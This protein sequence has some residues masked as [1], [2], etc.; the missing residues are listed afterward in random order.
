MCLRLAAFLS[1]ISLLSSMCIWVVSRPG[2][3]FRRALELPSVEAASLD[4]VEFYG[5][6]LDHDAYV[7]CIDRSCS[8]GWAGEIDI[9]KA[10][11]ID[12]LFQLGSG[13]EFSLVAF[14]SSYSEWSSSLVP[15]DASA[16]DDALSWV[17]FITAT[18]ST[19]LVA[20]V[21]A[22]IDIA[23]ESANSAVLLVCDGLPSCGPEGDLDVDIA[24]IAAANPLSVPIHTFSVSG[25]PAANLYLEGIAD[26]FGGVYVDTATAVIGSFRRGDANWDGAVDI[27][28]AVFLLAAAFISG[29]PAPPCL[30]AADCNDDGSYDPILDSAVLLQS[31]FVP[32]SLPVAPPFSS[33]GGDPT[34]DTLICVGQCP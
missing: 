15:A 1:I 18:G 26:A 13:D 20:P 12:A 8:M 19:C 30:D 5:A 14:D 9:V 23:D 6:C 10:A 4:G 2:S 16:V 25:D 34:P 22:A 27:A 31:I 33:C 21:S 24:A 29:S 3:N 28:D 17:Q 7:W 32:G 11:V